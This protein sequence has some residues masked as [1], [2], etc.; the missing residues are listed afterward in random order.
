MPAAGVQGSD[1][2]LGESRAHCQ[3]VT[4]DHTRLDQPKSKDT[5]M[6]KNL[7]YAVGVLSWGRGLR[8]WGRPRPVDPWPSSRTLR[9]GGS[10]NQPGLRS[11][12]AVSALIGQL[13]GLWGFLGHWWQGQWRQEVQ[14]HQTR[15][16]VTFVRLRRYGV[17]RTYYYYSVE[18]RRYSVGSSML[19]DN[20]RS[21]RRGQ[22]IASLTPS[23]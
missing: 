22:P 12:R 1:Q 23:R 6:R 8:Q 4:A 16:F 9:R 14:K 3:T 2:L 10:G 15:L 17:L 20:P 13:A 5:Y 11:L 19:S 21:T 7:S 18:L